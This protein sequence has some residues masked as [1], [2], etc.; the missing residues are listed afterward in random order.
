VFR[1]RDFSAVGEEAFVPPTE[2]SQF[3]IFA[4]KDYET[5][6]VR[7]ELGGRYE[8][9]SHEVV[10][11]GFE[12]NF[13]SFSVSGGVGFTP[14]E[15]I[16]FGVSG[17]R[18][19]RAPSTEEL[20]SNGPHLATDAFE[21]GDPT[22]EEEVGRGVEATARYHNDRFSLAL[23][24]FYT[25]YNDF[26]Y[27]VETGDIEDGLSVFAFQADDATFRGFEFEAE[28]ELFK[29]GK[30][31]IHADGAVDFVRATVD[32]DGNDNLP[33]IPPLTLL[34]GIEAKSVHGDFRFEVEHANEQ[35]NVT[36]FELPTDSY[37]VLNTYV[38]LRPFH[39]TSGLAIRLAATNLTNEEVR[40]HTSFLKD[41]V[42]LP[43]R[44][45]R[46]SVTGRF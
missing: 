8:S 44:N 4:L 21:L 23:N 13:D 36:E 3:G 34:A 10:E 11:T 24:G 16:F 14:Q 9:T 37:T 40:L 46:I 29:V 6:P 22:L 35:D 45:F 28:A 15:H 19:E 25:S 38:T 18:T 41:L 42:P 7:F 30:F 27:E 12:R 20:F 1:S 17:F 2:T 39:E 26:I 5:G 31:D 32:V 33:R 43:G